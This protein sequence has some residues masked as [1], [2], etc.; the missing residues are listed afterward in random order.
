MTNASAR[1]R[2]TETVHDLHF[3]KSRGEADRFVRG[4]E[5]GRASDVPVREIFRDGPLSDINGANETEAYRRSIENFVGTVKVP[6]GLAGPLTVRGMFADG[7]YYLPLATTEAALVAS[8]S[9]GAEAVSAAGGCTTAVLAESI[10]RAP[11]LVFD[12]LR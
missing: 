10:S 12:S 8:Y 6:V 1:L 5:P 2:Q 3:A 9:R 4:Y 7:E 11:G